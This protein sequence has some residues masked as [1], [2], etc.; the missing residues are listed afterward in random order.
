MSNTE[1][2]ILAARRTP[3]GRFLGGL[4]RVP[5]P[6]LGACAITAALQDA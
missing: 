4:S 5:A 1:T 2:V 3:I 6:E